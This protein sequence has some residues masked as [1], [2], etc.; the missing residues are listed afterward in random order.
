MSCLFDCCVL[1]QI[2]GGVTRQSFLTFSTLL[3]FLVV[4]CCDCLPANLIS[5]FV[6]VVVFDCLEFW[7]VF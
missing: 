6:W 3:Y 5:A 2:C 4:F 1:A 7:F